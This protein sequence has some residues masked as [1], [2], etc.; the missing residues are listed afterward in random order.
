M[1]GVSETL[2]RQIAE[3]ACCVPF[4]SATSLAEAIAL[5]DTDNWDAARSQILR[6]VSQA[7][8]RVKASTLL[9]TW[10][11]QAPHVTS[12]AVALALISAAETEAQHR[13]QEETELVWTGPDSG[14]IPLRRTDQA[15]LQ[16]IRSTQKKLLIVSFAVYHIPEIS[17]AL[18][19]AAQ[20]DVKI[21]ICLDSPE[22]GEGRIAYGTL[23]ALGDAV[24]Q[25]ATVYRW[26]I[27]QRPLTPHGRPASLHAKCAVGDEDMLFI[28]SANLTQYAMDLNMELGV[29][30]RGGKLPGQVARHFARLVQEAIL[31]P[32]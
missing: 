5:A 7:G 1:L 13:Q 21:R 3:L 24:I 32:V 25:H 10:R 8:V 30:I 18:V 17:N 28:S 12:Q 27:E 2:L 15:L 19:E 23:Q 11:T 31:E 9:D 20:R 6:S 4:P 14:V 29:L 22:P 26:P 16:V